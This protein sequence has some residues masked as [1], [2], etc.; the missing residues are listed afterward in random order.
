MD[1]PDEM[2]FAFT[3]NSNYNMSEDGSVSN[4]N[5]YEPKGLPMA[6]SNLIW[7]DNLICAKV[8]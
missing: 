6:H 1:Y 2:Y 3:L 4:R 7:N 5:A 8:K